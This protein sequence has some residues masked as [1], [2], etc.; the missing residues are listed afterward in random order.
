VVDKGGMERTGMGDGEGSTKLS[1]HGAYHRRHQRILERREAISLYF[2]DRVD[3]IKHY[4]LQYE[5]EAEILNS[6]LLVFDN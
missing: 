5:K 6:S 1:S 2:L 4:M 3:I